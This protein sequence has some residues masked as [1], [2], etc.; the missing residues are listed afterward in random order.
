MSHREI[1]PHLIK[2]LISCIFALTINNACFTQVIDSSDFLNFKSTLIYQSTTFWPIDKGKSIYGAKIRKWRSDSNEIFTI[3]S[4]KFDNEIAALKSIAYSANSNEFPC[5]FGS[6]IGRIFGDNS[7][8]SID[9]RAIHFQL[10]CY[11][12]KIFYPFQGP[13]EN[14]LLQI[15][16]T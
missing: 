13:K 5:S 14:N 10:G 9:G 2:L 11:G 4:F 8:T 6:N 16:D 1:I 12:V 15:A 3:I 7:W